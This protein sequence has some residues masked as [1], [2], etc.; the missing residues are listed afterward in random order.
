MK[1]VVLF[2]VFVLTAGA[3]RAQTAEV[4]F[5]WINGYIFV[6]ATVD[7]ITGKYFFDTGA[8]MSL[9][10]ARAQ[11]GNYTP[12]GVM[13][14][15]DVHGRMTDSIAVVV[16]RSLEMGQFRG[17]GLQVLALNK[18]NIVEV[19]GADGIVGSNFLTQMVVRFDS[20]RGVIT[21]SGSVEPYGLTEQ[22]G[23]PMRVEAAGHA[24]VNLDLGHGIVEEAMFDTG[25]NDLLDLSA[26]ARGR[27]DGGPAITPS[28]GRSVTV[29]QL[30]IGRGKFTDVAAGVLGGPSTLLGAQLL[31][32]G[33]VTLDYPHNRFY[34]EPYDK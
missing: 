27:L 12:I 19:T 6:D 8:P 18:G 21:F 1:K 30:N 31:K 28:E 13:P 24:F 2:L 34:F 26:S 9:T 3:A 29:G 5:E 25:S 7:S 32:H 11:K 17:G 14:I 22:D 16:V 10:H 20:R 4:P 33:I 23:L 15:R